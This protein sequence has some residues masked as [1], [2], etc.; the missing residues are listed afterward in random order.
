[1]VLQREKPVPIWGWAK[2]GEQVTVSFAGQ[3]KNSKADASGYWKVVLSALKTSA[4]PQNMLIAASDTIKLSNILVG[5]VWLCS[6]QSN[7]EYTLKLGPSYAKPKKGIDSAA[8][9]LTKAH[10]NLRLFKVEKVLSTPD[11]TTTGWN[12]C[13]GVAL[14]QFS[15]IGF[16]FAKNIQ[17]ELKDVPIGMITSSW[18]GSR[19]E[20]WT[21]AE[22]Y[23]ALPAF[24]PES[25]KTPFMIDSV[26]SGKDYRSMILPLAPFALR[27]F[28]W[29]QGESNCMLNDGMRYA[30]KMQALVDG[31]RK[32]WGNDNLP[33]Y[34]VQIAP[35]YYTK[36]KDH[37][38]H[39]AETEAEFWEAQTQSLKI[40]H[41]DMITVTDLVDNLTDIHPPYKWEVGRRLALLALNHD[42]NKKLIS[43]GPVYKSMKVEKGKVILTFNN[44]VGLKSMDNKPLSW[45]TIAG[46][47]GKFVPA[48]A[49][50]K[51][52]KILVSATGITN[53]QAVR[54]AWQETAMPN[55][56]NAA[57]LPAVPF[58]TDGLSWNYKK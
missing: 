49:E 30:D 23:Q 41:T 45:F 10:P 3:Q 28:L 2:P 35:Y 11:V 39:T 17:Q 46:S 44:S 9:E 50:I 52:D 14:E 43:S 32:Q 57:N 12:D 29:Y 37:V 31:W 48:D 38:P 56:F 19:I 24:A 7:M 58:R 47:D 36:R 51:G 16:Y 13:S 5:E 22:A 21:P 26:A 53:P 55:L 40:P 18:G 42:Y 1:M 27:G 34:S 4:Q 15:A 25:Q 54:F 8:L 20:P 33:F 6:G